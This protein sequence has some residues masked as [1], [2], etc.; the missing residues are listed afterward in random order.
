MTKGLPILDLAS[1]YF[2][3]CKTWCTILLLVELEKNESLLLMVKLQQNS[4]YKQC[5]AKQSQTDIMK[6]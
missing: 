4:K 1:S 2:V 5:K 3:R 6:S